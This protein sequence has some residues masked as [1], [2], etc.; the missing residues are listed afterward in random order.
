LRGP[1]TPAPMWLVDGSVAK[2]RLASE[3]PAGVGCNK[4]LSDFASLF[5]KLRNE[6]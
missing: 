5:L 2:P 1:K 4:V 6:G 3:W